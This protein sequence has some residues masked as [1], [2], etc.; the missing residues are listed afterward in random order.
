M[1][2]EIILQEEVANLGQIGDVVN[3]RTGYARNYLLPRGFAVEANRRNVRAL[4][5]QKRL[6]AVKKERVESQAQATSEQLSAVS[7]TIKARSGEEGRLF[8]SV[9][10]IDIEAALKEKGITVNRRK[11]LL[12]EPI[13]QLGEHEVVVNIGGGLRANIKV[14][15]TSDA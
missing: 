10:N 12:D 11:I 6:V 5:H 1:A 7:L 2:M 3:V 8:G 13:K 4:E 9:T 14:E 15:V